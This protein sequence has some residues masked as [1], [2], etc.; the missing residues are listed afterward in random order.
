MKQVARCAFL[1]TLSAALCWGAVSRLTS[2]EPNWVEPG[3]AV[4][5]QGQGLGKGQVVKLFLTTGSKD[6]EV[7][8]SEQTPES[9]GFSIPAR[10]AVMC[11][12]YREA[13]QEA[14]LHSEPP[15]KVSK[16]AFNIFPKIREIDEIMHTDK[17][18][19]GVLRECHPELCF[20]ALND[21]QAMQHN[22]KQKA[23]RQERLAVLERFFPPCHMLHNRASGELLRRQVA[24]DDII[25]A[26]VCAVTAKCGYGSYQTV[27]AVPQTDGRG[28]AMEMVYCQPK[29]SYPVEFE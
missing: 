27:P 22:K 8:I 16:Q 10:S 15:R 9:L 17:A 28:L 14:L 11:N 3:D 18:L 7:E 1:L 26:M 20:W 2:V 19:R 13:C 25:D 6:I 5:A 12:D 23:G 4:V 29:G 24:H 21:R